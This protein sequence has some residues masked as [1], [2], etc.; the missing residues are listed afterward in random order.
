[1]VAAFL[2]LELAGTAC[3]GTSGCSDFNP[4]S[5]SLS[6]GESTTVDVDIVNGGWSTPDVSGHYWSTREPVPAGAPE[7]GTITGRAR[8]V[9]PSR[10]DIDFGDLGVVTFTGPI[11]C[12]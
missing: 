5:E 1:M 9:N 3:G 10:V 2:A 12:M 6:T 11:G 8:L 4:S 7:E